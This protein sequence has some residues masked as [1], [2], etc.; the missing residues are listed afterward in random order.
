LPLAR[1]SVPAST[2]SLS[3]S[4]HSAMRR[5]RSARAAL[6]AVALPAVLAVVLG[7]H[8]RTRSSQDSAFAMTGTPPPE[9]QRPKREVSQQS[10]ASRVTP[11]EAGVHIADR[12]ALSQ[13]DLQER[14]ALRKPLPELLMLRFPSQDEDYRQ[15][16]LAD[17]SASRSSINI[18]LVGDGSM[19]SLQEELPSIWR[20]QAS[21]VVFPPPDETVHVYD[22]T[23]LFDAPSEPKRHGF[24]G[25]VSAP[26][27]PL[28]SSSSSAEGIEW[29]GMG[30]FAPSGRPRDFDGVHVKFAVWRCDGAS[31]TCRLQQEGEDERA[32]VCEFSSLKEGVLQML[33]G[34]SRRF[35]VS[36][37]VED[38]RFGRPVPERFLPN[39]NLV[40]DITLLGIQREAVFD[41]KLS[42]E[43]LEVRNARDRNPIVMLQRAFGVGFQLCVWT[44]MYSYYQDP[45]GDPMSNVFGLS[46]SMH[47]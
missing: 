5:T 20:V 19:L 25:K 29:N 22:A 13:S 45:A 24:L 2:A 34:E 23:P 47:L 40:V 14:F 6:I 27:V 31:G 15:A 44:L 36:D 41:Y 7:E 9:P 10:L 39:G 26:H 3:A 42:D 11:L 37:T 18:S 32:L 21:D 46:H 16:R 28:R 4:I 8:F 43:A 1:R 12:A 38:R 35:W 17:Y 33:P 30:G